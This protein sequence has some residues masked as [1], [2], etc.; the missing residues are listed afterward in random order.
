MK[1]IIP[2]AA[3]IL[4]IIFQSCLN[5]LDIDQTSYISE[6]E[7]WDSEED[8]EQAVNGAYSLFRQAFYLK[9]FNYG[10][11]RSG[12]YL[13]MVTSTDDFY[14]YSNN[15]NSTV[16]CGTDWRPIYNVINECNL[17]LR[18]IDNIEFDNATEKDEYKAHAYFLR[19]YCYF[20]IA[21]IWGDA[22]IVL[23][24]TVSADQDDIYPVRSL[25]SDVFSQAEKDILAA[26]KNMPASCSDIK[27][28]TTAAVKMLKADYYLWM[29]RCEGQGTPALETA[30]AALDDV[31]SSRHEMADNFKDIF[32]VENEN[33]PELI[34]SIDMR[35]YEFAN[36]YFAYFFP[37]SSNV[38]QTDAI[39]D[40]ILVAST[41]YKFRVTD[42][43]MELMTEDS[44]DK[45]ASLSFGRYDYGRDQFYTWPNK[46]TGEWEYGQRYHTS[47]II[48]YRLAEAYL[49]KAEI[50]WAMGQNE[51][52]CNYLNTIASRAYG[53]DDFYDHTRL[54][55]E[56]L[57]EEIIDEYLKE[58][59]MEC[60]SWW[61]FIRFDVV[62]DRSSFLEGRNGETNILLWP[63]YSDCINTNK[64]ITQT[65]GYR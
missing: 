42:E 59:C 20:W 62:F 2:S 41:Q 48:V 58:F 6:E 29:G 44:R 56:K 37:V 33:N 16:N 26:E 63:V 53:V 17:I 23:S 32:G 11:L 19:G 35:K 38:T 27:K 43:Y 3:L 15:L 7:M 28:A 40:P 46:F 1:H 31:I 30:S 21:R 25:Q 9:L 64:N 36:S 8:F 57:K 50:A 60:K 61:M 34:F 22:P 10:D 39:N 52:A 24:G 65:V 18:H 4:C 55:S 12:Q 45:R 51:L 5:D 47:D 49:M 14:V 54:S 13:C